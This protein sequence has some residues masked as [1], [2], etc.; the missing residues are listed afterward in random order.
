MINDSIINLVLER[1]S[2]TDGLDRIKLMYEL[3]HG[4]LIGVDRVKAQYGPKDKPKAY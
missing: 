1:T 4:P 2:S 3:S